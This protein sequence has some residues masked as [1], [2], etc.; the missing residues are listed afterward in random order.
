MRVNEK[1]TPGLE[2]KNYNELCSVL[3]ISNEGGNTKKANLKSIERFCSLEK[4]GHKY[5][6]KEIYD[7]PKEK[8]DKRVKGNRAIYTAMI[9]TILL[10][11]F[12]EKS[13]SKDSPSLSFTKR[14][15]WE[16]LGMI[17]QNYAANYKRPAF[18]TELQ[19]IDDRVRQWH[20]DKAYCNSRKKLNDI[21]K[22]A[23]Q[24]LKRRMLI[25]YR[26]DVIVAKKVGDKRHFEVK[27]EWQ[28]EKILQCKKETLIELGCEN[29]HDV[30]FNKDKSITLEAY[31]KIRNAKLQRTLGFEFVYKRYSIICNR[32][33]MEQGLQENINFLRKELNASII[34]VLTKQATKDLRKNRKALNEGRTSFIYPNYYEDIQKLI[35]N[36]ILNIDEALVEEFVNNIELQAE[37]DELFAS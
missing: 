26:D 14:E 16:E 23:L 12:I 7:T 22:S 10:S 2:L 13:K 4:Q 21:T 29:L 32:K 20:I 37:L 34:N 28:I 19:H 36:K 5:I 8:N 6:V 25:E 31:Y 9:E 24:S 33:Y 18:L 3:E 35:I 11:V 15:L 30:I 27:E 17:S 1:L